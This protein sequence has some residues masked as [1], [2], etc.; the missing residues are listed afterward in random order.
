MLGVSRVAT[1]KA[2]QQLEQKHLIRRRYGRTDIKDIAGLR[3]FI[4]EEDQF[5]S[6]E[7][8]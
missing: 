2:L 6:V 8:D 1:G 3:S 4:A 7:N 5:Y